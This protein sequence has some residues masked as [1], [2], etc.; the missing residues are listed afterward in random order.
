M[1]WDI[2]F[3]L[4]RER[5][6]KFLVILRQIVNLRNEESV[7]KKGDKIRIYKNKVL[8]D[9]TKFSTSF[10]SFIAETRV[11]NFILIDNGLIELEVIDKTNKE[12]GEVE[13]TV[14][15]DVEEGEDE[16]GEEEF[17][18]EEDEDDEAEEFEDEEDEDD[19][20]DD[21]SDDDGGKPSKKPKKH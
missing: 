6:G 4:R 13:S 16:M 20:E 9:S 17:D 1:L 19:D 12:G 7:I 8:G 3:E 18:E 21:V 5:Y 2:F 10:D 11:G 15:D 14:Y